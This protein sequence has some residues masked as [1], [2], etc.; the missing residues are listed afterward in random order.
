MMHRT[1]SVS[2][3]LMALALLAWGGITVP[4]AAGAQVG[5][6]RRQQAAGPPG[7]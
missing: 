1:G 4:A 6:N 2:L 7:L 5:V 3:V